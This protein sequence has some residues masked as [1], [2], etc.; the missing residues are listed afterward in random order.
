MSEN[1]GSRRRSSRRN[2]NNGPNKRLKAIALMLTCLMILLSGLFWAGWQH[3]TSIDVSIKNSK[4]RKQLDDLEIEK[5]RLIVAREVS[6]SPAEIRKSAKKLAISDPAS[7]TPSL[8]VGSKD[9]VASMT[10]TA[11]LVRSIVSAAPVKPVTNAVSPSKPV[12]RESPAGVP[13]APVAER[14]RI[15]KLPVA[16]VGLK[17]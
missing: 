2:Y 13:Q 16:S 6:L 11:P 1:A 17:R 14:S 12:R 8:P 15:A 5:R 10:R 7:E 3:F 4:L 9:N